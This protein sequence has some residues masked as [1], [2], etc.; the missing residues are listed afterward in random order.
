MNKFKYIL[1]LSTFFIFINLLAFAY[2]Y[3]QTK[4]NMYSNEF[5][6]FKKRFSKNE[7]KEIFPHPFFGYNNTNNK[8]IEND[9]K[10]REPLFNHVPENIKSSD[11]KILI[12]GGSVATHLSHNHSED[13]FK[14]DDIN[15]D[16]FDIFQ[17][18]L[19][20]KFKTDRFK[21]INAAIPGGKQPQQLFKFNYLLLNGYTFDIVLN[22]DGINELALS[23]AEN[24]PIKNN[25]IYPRQFSRQIKAFN[26]NISCTINSNKSIHDKSIFPIKEL[27]N[28]FIIYSCH[29]KIYGIENQ[30]DE[31]FYNLSKFKD[32]GF[33]VK[34]AK[35]VNLWK[36]SSNMISDLSK[37][38][39]FKYIH[40]LQP[41]Q[42]FKDSKL[43]TKKEK[44]IS[45]FT[46]Y[47]NPISKYYE[48]FNI[49][50]VQA[51]YKFDSRYIFKS[52]NENLYRDYCCHLNNRGMYLLSHN[53]I[54]KFEEVFI[55]Y[56]R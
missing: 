35:V 16:K 22:L 26:T 50:E 44:E 27:Y 51:K 25:I 8:I 4:I 42:Y 54:E 7:T 30:I 15:Y 21:V 11:I 12:L 56:I 18:A 14:V 34:L 23:I 48:K 19:N 43:L 37:N 38:Y 41:N 10:N 24:I 40:V 32:E 2:I 28:L 46:K 3:S 45:N 13:T 36:R 9:L 31:D 5:T 39:N 55:P 47:S 53:I 1:L 49:D 6:S 33:N 29:K 52:N 20:Q 17:K